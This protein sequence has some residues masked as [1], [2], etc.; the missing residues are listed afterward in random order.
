MRG[1]TPPWRRL[2][3]VLFTN[4]WEAIHPHHYLH[5]MASICSYHAPF[6]LKTISFA[7]KKRFHFRSFSARALG[8][9]EAVANA[10][11][12]PMRDASPFKWLDWLFQNTARVLKS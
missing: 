10:W 8:F 6:I 4:E 3:A 9:M 1:H 12:C 5:S 11:R 2:I 7:S